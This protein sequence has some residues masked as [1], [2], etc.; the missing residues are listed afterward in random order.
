MSQAQNEPIVEPVVELTPD[1]QARKWREKAMNCPISNT[2]TWLPIS[3]RVTKESKHVG[4][5]MCLRCFHEINISE[6]FKYRVPR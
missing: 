5:L 1:Q 3:W 2:H 6:A 4:S